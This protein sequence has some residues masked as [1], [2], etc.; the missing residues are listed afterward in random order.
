MIKVNLLREPTVKAH[1]RITLPTIS[2]MGLILLAIFIVC[3][4]GLGGWW[5]LLDREIGRL[6]VS[7]EQL[8]IESA[9]LQALRKQLVEFEKLKNQQES[10]IQVIEKLKDAQTG[11][12]QLLN[13]LIR[14]IPANSNMWLTLVDQKGERLQIVGYAGRSE[15]IPDFMINLSASGL[16]K[17]VDLEL[18]QE[19][20]EASK[21]SLLCQNPQRVPKE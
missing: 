6:T 9:R 12:V 1:R 17:S 21:F 3:A 11:P 8:R 16:F 7:R 4:A 15:A 20:K 5:Y 18:V 19:D 2:S 10:R 13:A 14:C